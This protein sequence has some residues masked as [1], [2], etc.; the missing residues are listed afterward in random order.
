M[1]VRIYTGD[2]GQSHFEEL[3]MESGPFPWGE[4][5]DA[6]GVIFNRS[7]IGSFSDWHN[8]PRRQFVITLSG[9]MEVG[10]ADGTLR[11]FG[12]GSVLLADD[13][14]G[15]GHTTRTVGDEPRLSVS[16]PIP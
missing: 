11:Q 8:A 2:D 13:L 16:V 7:Q 14:T 3:D 6:T 15:Q 5:R 10:I 1:I 12:P 4:L 9:A